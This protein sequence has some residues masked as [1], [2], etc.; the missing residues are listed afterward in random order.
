MI[1]DVVVTGIGCLL[2]RAPNAAALRPDAAAAPA[3]R[4]LPA[5]LPR[6]AAWGCPAPRLARM[7]RF[8]QVTFLAAHEAFVAA[9]LP[10]RPPRREGLGLCFGTAYGCHAVNEAYYRGFLADGARGASPRLFAAT[11][12]SSPLGELAIALDARGPVLALTEGWHAGLQAVA[13]AARLCHRGQ[14]EVILAGGSDV[15]SDTL[16]R[17]LADWGH[18]LDLAE[19]AV[20][21]VVE[22]A[23][24]A[25]ARGVRPLAA[26]LGAGGAFAPT[27][28][29][30]RALELATAA[31]LRE[32]GL[33]P[34]ALARRLVARAPATPPPAGAAPGDAG[35][36]APTAADPAAR[37]GVTLGAGGVLAVALALREEPV[38]LTLVGATDPLGGAAALVLG[39][40]A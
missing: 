25:R 30:G 13:E 24:A 22:Q 1:R 2:A 28:A 19:G 17:L 33:A 37:F 21:V 10:A 32:A 36:A 20:F 9:D 4:C 35:G 11:L 26:I 5:P 16:V 15:L 8:S 40:P 18:A 38:G 29:P 31:A 14:A 23:T 39:P 3:G 12:P 34:A 6:P 27:P 7:D